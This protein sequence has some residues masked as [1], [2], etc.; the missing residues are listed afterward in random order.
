MAR[1]TDWWVLG[2]DQDPTPGVVESVQDLATRFHTFAD[3]VER[4]HK[5][6]LSLNGDQITLRWIGA[7]GDTFRAAF[8]TFPDDLQKLF[9]S[10][11][12]V[13]DALT[14]YW[15]KLQTAQTNADQACAQAVQVHDELATAQGQLT[16]AQQDL[17]TAQAHGADTSAHLAAQST[18]QSK[19]ADAQQ[20]LNALK[21]TAQQACDDRLAAARACTDSIAAGGNAGIHNKHWW[22]KLGEMISDAAG[23]IAGIT[24]EIAQITS[25]IAPVL[26]VIALATAEIPG[27]DVVTAGLALGDNL[28]AEAS[29]SVYAT[30]TGLKAD[31]ELLQGHYKA[32]FMDA[33]TATMSR[34]GTKTGGGEA[35]VRANAIEGNI[36]SEAGGASDELLNYADENIGRTNVA[37][38]VVAQD[39]T[40]GF[41]LSMP[42]SLEDLTPAVRTAVEAT[43]HHG[44]CAEI[45]GLC[46]IER[47]G[48]SIYGSHGLAIH[49]MGGTQEYPAEVHGE[50]KP[51][52]PDC[53]SLFDYLKASPSS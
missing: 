33:A 16:V 37:A 13:G 40:H 34:V 7:S 11:R 9:T 6:V 38:E 31:G 27:L 5:D 19:V 10:Y 42:R 47:Q 48:A 35:N 15:P 50:L 41:G 45:G 24:G 53:T 21:A 52:C 28:L 1:P 4:A 32:A 26:D 49:V 14:A 8:S 3:D 36:D 43:G 30:A 39:G 29:S 12:M 22:Q 23:E 25:L 18:A 51:L 20:R 17:K 46:D 44:G 2:L